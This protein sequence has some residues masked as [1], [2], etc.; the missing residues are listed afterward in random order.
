M[1]V[2]CS[3]NLRIMELKKAEIWE[4]HQVAKK[5]QMDR[6]PQRACHGNNRPQSTSS[7]YC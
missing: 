7:V 5:N 3:R 1:Q 2:G 6:L 4:R